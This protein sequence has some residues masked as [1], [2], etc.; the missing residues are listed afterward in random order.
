MQTFLKSLK[1][2]NYCGI[3]D[4]SID[5]IK[6]DQPRP[7]S[8]FYAP[9]GYG[10]STILNAI[11][12]LSFPW[13][14]MGREV[15]LLLRKLTFHPDYNPTYM[16]FVE[17]K[18]MMAKAVFLIDG[19]EKVV[20]LENTD[21]YV[22]VV[23]CDLQR[24]DN[25]QPY[26]FFVDADNPMNAAR[27]QL[28]PVYK[29]EFIDIAE[30]VYSFKCEIPSGDMYEVEEF[31]RETGEH[32]IFHT[33]LIIHKDNGTKVHFKSMSAGE[34]KIAVM[35]SMLFSPLNYSNY[36]VFLIDNL[37]LHLYW[38]RHAILIDKLMKFFHD[39]QIIATTHSGTM[40]DHVANQYGQKYLFD[41]EEMLSAK[42][43]LQ[44]VTI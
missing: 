39:K 3:Q 37:E 32:V 16:A 40:I 43:V 11:R 15:D 27:F 24:R 34:R 28:N 1:L 25:Y 19:E 44:K 38:K 4:L 5:F 21:D 12:S 9:N 35:L 30:A 6:D 41:L 33:D 18:G 26:A 13:A 22:G 42:P 36:N 29:D 10:K 14:L 7:L 20:H 17:S 2:H 31:D 23:Q 8:L